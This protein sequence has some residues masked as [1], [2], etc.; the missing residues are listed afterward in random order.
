M[1]DF[2]ASSE[3]LR[4]DRIAFRAN[5]RQTQPGSGS[6]GWWTIARCDK[7]GPSNNPFEVLYRDWEGR[8]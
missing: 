8:V 5:A 4:A 2:I 3:E 1:E 6:L 7:G